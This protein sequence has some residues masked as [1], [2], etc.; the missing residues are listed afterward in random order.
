[1]SV[2]LTLGVY[3]TGNGAREGAPTEPEVHY[4]PT[5]ILSSTART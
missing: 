3:I 5:D 1:M 2:E 4:N